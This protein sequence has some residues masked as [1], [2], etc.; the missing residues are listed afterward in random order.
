ML[1]TMKD[2]QF[3]EILSNSLEEHIL[4]E[5]CLKLGD[6]IEFFKRTVSVP[7]EDR[8]LSGIE[9]L[10]NLGAIELAVTNDG[11]SYK[12]QLTDLGQWLGNVPQHPCATLAMSYSA[13]FGVLL[14]T[15]CAL[16]FM[17]QKSPFDIKKES[18]DTTRGG[19]NFLGDRFNS[20][21]AALVN[22]YLGWKHC[23]YL[24]EDQKLKPEEKMN[25]ARRAHVYLEKHGLAKEL[26]GGADQNVK[27]Y[28]G[29]MVKERGYNGEDCAYR[30][31]SPFWT[32]NKLFTDDKFLLFKLALL[33]SAKV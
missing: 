9:V 14:P 13:I 11:Q 5:M 33:C 32:T 18:M 30:L 6:P 20:D 8:V 26:V 12:Y 16:S 31:I 10:E 15:L 25:A 28:L 3:P 27:A 24:T 7:P 22:A 19:R 2:H 21:H 1:T 17:G 4:Q 23:I 29:L